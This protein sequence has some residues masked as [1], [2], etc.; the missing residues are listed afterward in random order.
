MSKLFTIIIP[1]YNSSA[2][3]TKTLECLYRQS[4]N[5]FLVLI[6]DDR[7]TDQ[8]VSVIKQYQK[9]KIE[10][11]VKEKKIPKGA[12]ASLNLA[13]KQVG[14]AYLA[15]IDSD[16]FLAKNWL[17]E[18]KK[19]LVLH[20][21]VGAPILAYR[22]NTPLGYLVGLEIESRYERI[23]KGR[24]GHLSSCNLAGKS[25]IFK[26]L[27]LSEKLLYAYDHQLSYLVTTANR[28]FY[29]TD[30]TYCFHLNKATFKNIFL[31]QF[32]IAKFHLM[33]AKKMPNKAVENDK[34][35]NKNL[36]IQPAIFL[37]AIVM[38]FLNIYIAVVFLF[39]LIIL[40]FNF[41]VYAS[42]RAGIKFLP[43]A[44]FYIFIRNL[45]WTAGAF[46]GIFIN[47]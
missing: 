34:I 9:L 23:K 20:E 27:R 2:Y 29:L 3:I 16:A 37:A 21:L 10:L 31:Q 18:I 46:V 30:K 47:L 13:F 32:N 42:T 11:V 7:S 35:S 45:A 24:L 36:A 39:F 1:T 41:L 22:K 4:E 5:N 19:E 33:L 12:A 26:N 40:N 6:I 38:F 8:T 14:T 17:A 44:F 15:I 43:L 25:E 28:K